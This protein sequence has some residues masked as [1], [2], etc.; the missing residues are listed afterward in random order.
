MPPP[1]NI[2]PHNHPTRATEHGQNWHGPCNEKTGPNGNRTK[3]QKNHRLKQ[4]RKA[5]VFY[6]SVPQ[7]VGPVFTQAPCPVCFPWPWSL[8]VGSVVRGSVV[9]GSV[10]GSGSVVR[11]CGSGSGPGRWSGLGRVG[12]GRFVVLGVLVLVV[13]FIFLIFFDHKIQQPPTTAQLLPSHSVFR[14]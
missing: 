3:E 1:P 8:V 12:R 5:V 6:G 13:G 9:L 10:V 4:Q 11:S 2:H 7:F 14:R